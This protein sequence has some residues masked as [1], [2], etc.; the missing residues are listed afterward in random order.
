MKKPGKVLVRT[1]PHRFALPIGGPALYRL[2]QMGLCAYVTVRTFLP[3]IP[4]ILWMSNPSGKPK[5]L[6]LSFGYYD[7]MRTGWG[8]C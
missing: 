8:P 7:E 6:P 3:P 5:W 1:I 2:S 4:V